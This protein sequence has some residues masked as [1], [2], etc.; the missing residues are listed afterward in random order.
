MENLRSIE[1][2]VRAA[3]GGSIAAAARRLGITPAAASQNIARLEEALGTRLLL[4][5]TRRL[6]LTEAGRVYLERVGGI[7]QELELASAAVSAIGERPR[8]RLKVACSVAF[9]RHVLSTIIPRFTALY[10]EISFELKL[11]D[12]AAD[13]F[14]D[15]VDVSIRF[16]QQLEPGLITRKLN[17]APM[18]YCAAPAYLEKHGA[19]MRPEDL[20]RHDCLVYRLP[21][22]G[23]IMTWGFV[24]AGVRFDAPV[25][26]AIVGNDIDTLAEFAVEGAG[27]TRLGAFISERYLREGSLVRVLV[28]QDPSIP[29]AIPEPLDFHI[30]VV[31]RL[32]ETPKVR[33]FIDFAVSELK[34]RW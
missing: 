24:R 14:G 3:E 4:R 1:C 11:G 7:L 6:A 31:D 2:F 19:P 9:G 15:D 21:I 17:S 28:D 5:T 22:D 34:N 29:P 23:R 12:F 25:R 8:G 33:A 10:P 13:H 32:A 26:P 30:C 27:I 18:H 20:A 16:Q